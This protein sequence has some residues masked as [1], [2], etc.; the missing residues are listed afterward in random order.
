MF[1]RIGQVE[2]LRTR[3]YRLDAHNSG[4]MIGT[5]VVVAEGTYPVLSDGFSTVM[6]LTGLVDG[7]SIRRGDGVFIMQEG[8]APLDGLEVT[9]P[10]RVFDSDEWAELIAH[11]TAVEGHPDQR[12]RVTLDRQEA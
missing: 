4:S 8:D 5:R 1:K 10:S 2:V 12:L 9:F 6:M 7:N 3:I 11:P